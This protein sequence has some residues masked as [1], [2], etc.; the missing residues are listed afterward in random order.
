MS[1]TPS[2]G[3][4]ETSGGTASRPLI[5]KTGADAVEPRNFQLFEQTM[6]ASWKCWN[7]GRITSPTGCCSTMMKSPEELQVGPQLTDPDVVE[8]FDSFFPFQSTFFFQLTLWCVIRMEYMREPPHGCYTFLRRALL[9][10]LLTPAL[11]HGVYQGLHDNRK[12]GNIT[13]YCKVV[14]YLF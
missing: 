11:R 6:T 8:G 1:S 5:V 10:P 7:R 9:S 14:I 3:E 2:M 13:S 12:E 4:Y